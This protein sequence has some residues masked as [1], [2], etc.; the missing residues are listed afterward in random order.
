MTHLTDDDLVLHF[1][2]ETDAPTA[3]R[4]HLADCDACRARFADLERVMLSIHE[5]AVPERDEA[6][7]RRVWLRLQ[8]ALDAERVRRRTW[9]RHSFTVPRMVTA[10]A[11]ASLLVAAFVAGR[12]ARLPGEAPAQGPSNGGG[13]QRILLIAVSDHL[14]RSAIVLAEISNLDGGPI[15]D[16]SAEQE[17]ASDLVA[18]N[19]LYRQVALRGDDPGI[20]GVLDDLERVLVEIANSPSTMAAEELDQIRARIAGQGLLF[21]VRVLGSRVRQEA[22]APSRQ[23]SS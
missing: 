2:R 7:G 11:L 3:A 20:A 13:P 18:S 1:Y 17:V 10:G 4:E 15:V 8:P 16:I 9:W 6:Y 21:K 22:A 14:E 12:Y 23:A 19:R 5:E